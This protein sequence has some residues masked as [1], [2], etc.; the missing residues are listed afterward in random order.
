VNHLTF[1]GQCFL[2]LNKIFWNDGIFQNTRWAKIG[3]GVQI[4]DRFADHQKKFSS[5]LNYL[6]IGKTYD[7]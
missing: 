3:W 4:F 5:S 6:G 2:L 7:V 1:P